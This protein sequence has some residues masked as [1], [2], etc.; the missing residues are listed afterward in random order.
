MNMREEIYCKLKE[1]EIPN[2]I[3]KIN[4]EL[5]LY[6]PYPI[7]G[8]CNDAVNKI[9]NETLLEFKREKQIPKIPK[10]GIGVREID[11]MMELCNAILIYNNRELFVRTPYLTYFGSMRAPM[12]RAIYK[13][14][15]N[16]NLTQYK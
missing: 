2:L 12:I 6:T 13:I 1:I 8:W 14:Y 9:R 3:S 11:R 7:A 16:E 15:K 4:V 10:W 5:W